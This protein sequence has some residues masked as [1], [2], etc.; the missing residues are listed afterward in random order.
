MEP[1]HN[2]HFLRMAEALKPVLKSTPSPPLRVITIERD[3]SALLGWKAV[4][5]GSL[6]DVKCLKPGESCIL[7]FGGHRAGYFSFDL[8]D[9]PYGM[10]PADAP[11]RLK[12]VFGEVLNDVAESFEPY[13]GWLSKSWLPEEV[14]NVDYLPEHVA[15]PRRDAFRY[16][17]ITVVSTSLRFAVKLEN[18]LATAV[19][20]APLENPAPLIFP[21][22]LNLSTPDE[23][24]LQKIDTVAMETLRNC[25]QTVYEDGPRRDMRLWIGDLRLQALSSYCTFKDFNLVKRCLY[26]FAAMPYNDE[27]LLCACVYEK[28]KPRFGGNSIVDYSILYSVTLLD[29]VK[30]SQDFDTGRELFHIALKQ[31]EIHLRNLSAATYLYAVPEQTDG[32]SWHFIDWQE[33]LDRTTAIHCVLVFGLKAISELAALLALPPPTLATPAF[34]VKESSVDDLVEKLTASAR[35]ALFDPEKGLFISGPERQVSW[36][37]NAWAVIAGIPESREQGAKALRVAYGDQ[38]TVTATTP[39]LHHYVSHPLSTSY[40]YLG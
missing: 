19:T 1:A 32:G 31:F 33:K 3:E 28:P 8:V 39:Y 16:V 37:S 18:C 35:S 10:E 4:D 15:M 9:V 2:A 34:A 22:K 40:W 30:A 26:L 12:L 6:E 14:I 25:M 38:E 11:A 29:Y 17:K 20:S 7:D 13:E 21:A 5:A 23:A 36:A 24:L 27:G